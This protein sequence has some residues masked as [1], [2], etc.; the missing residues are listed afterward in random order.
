M[1]LIK[2]VEFSFWI[3]LGM[4]FSL[5][6]IG[7]GIARIK[8][9]IKKGNFFEKTWNEI[10]KIHELLTELR[11]KTRACRVQLIQFHNGGQFVDGI[12]M[13]RFSLCYE[14]LSKGISRE[15]NFKDVLVSLFPQFIGKIMKNSPEMHYSHLEEASIFRQILQHSNVM[16][17]SVLPVRAK[18]KIVGALILNWCNRTKA[19]EDPDLVIAFKETRDLVE[20]GIR[21]ISD[22]EN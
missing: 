4:A 18:G 2:G 22:Q 6:G 10:D 15:E 21:N 3:E 19:L 11:V 5:I 12:S 14:S 17:Y 20:L 7:F 9:I 13:K 8:K 16:Q 1:D